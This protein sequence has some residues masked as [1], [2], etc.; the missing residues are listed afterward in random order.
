MSRIVLW[1]LQSTELQVLQGFLGLTKITWILLA[2][3]YHHRD[4]WSK[5]SS[6]GTSCKHKLG[7]T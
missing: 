1:G 2:T 7:D 4:A 3:C 5:G 6:C